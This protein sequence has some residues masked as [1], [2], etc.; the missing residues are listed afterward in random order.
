MPKFNNFAT[1]TNMVEINRAIDKFLKDPFDE[2]AFTNEEG[3]LYNSSTYDA[4]LDAYVNNMYDAKFPP[5][6]SKLGRNNKIVDMTYE[7]LTHEQSCA[8]MLNPGGFEPQKRMGYLISAYKNPANKLTW[9]EL[10]SKT[11]KELK[12]L[13][14]TGKNLMYFDTHV[15]FYK[16]NSA[17]GS[18]I[19]IFAVHRTAH[20]ALETDNFRLDVASL[21]G[22]KVQDSINY[23]PFK[24]LNTSF[25]STME[26][27]P[28]FDTSGQSVG[29]VLGSLVASA[30]DAVKDPVL[31]LMNINS[32]TANILNTLVRLGMPFDDAALFLSQTAV[33]NVLTSFS[34]AKITKFKALNEI[35]KE[36]IDK[37]KRNL[38]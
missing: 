24:I 11:T 7:V 2:K 5:R 20:A 36:R 9:E 38:E 17:A 12:E 16:Q 23:S 27:D 34:K 4:L 29:K 14:S 6:N 33:E 18:L 21:L 19:G 25:N 31:N 22:K 10:E 1:S 30:A 15:Q 37:L 32:N 35:I 8:E 13:S 3:K 28:R 26:I